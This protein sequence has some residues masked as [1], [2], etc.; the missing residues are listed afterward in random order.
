MTSYGKAML[1]DFGQSRALAYQNSD[2]K[3][4]SYG[5]LKG[6]CRWMAYELLEATEDTSKPIICTEASDIWAF[7]MAIYASFF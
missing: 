3:T 4:S 6:S 2:L 5:R 1:A 7:G